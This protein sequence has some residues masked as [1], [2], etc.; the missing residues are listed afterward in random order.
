LSEILLPNL[1]LF[2]GEGGYQPFSRGYQPFWR[3]YQPFSLKYQPF[4]RIYQPFSLKYQPFKPIYQPI[5]NSSASA[6]ITSQKNPFQHQK[7]WKGF[8]ILKDL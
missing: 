6:G 2:Q 1:S 8:S 4:W 5:Q 7:E 3:I